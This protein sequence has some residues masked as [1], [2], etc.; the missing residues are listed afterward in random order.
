MT[1]NA[2]AGVPDLLPDDA[3][4]FFLIETA[5]R[6]VFSNYGYSYIQTPIF[7]LTDVFV[8]GIGDATDVV[9]K[10]MYH[11]F[12]QDAAKKLADNIALKSDQKLTLRPEG[13]A[14]IARAAV[15]HNLVQPKSAPVKLWYSGPMFRHERQQKGRYRQFHQIGAEFLGAFEPTADAEVI[16]MLMHFFASCG[17]PET[18]MR[19]TI[20]SMGDNN[21]RPAYR[22]SVRNFI[23]K[24]EDSLC[25]ECRR[26][27]DTNPLRAFDCKNPKCSEVMADAPRI[28][29]A[30]CM[31]CKQHYEQVKQILRDAGQSFSEDPRLVRGLDYYTRTVFEVQ[32]DAG[33]GAQNAIGGGGRYDKLLSEYG[34]KD[35]CGLGFAVG[36]ERI[37]LV[38]EEL[39]VVIPKPAHAELFVV[40]V[41]DAGLAGNDEASLELPSVVADTRRVAFQ[42][43][44]QLRKLGVSCDIDHQGRSLKSQF[45]LADKL[46]VKYCLVIG[47]DEL[48][49][50]S[51]ILR[52]MQSHEEEF[53]A[54]DTVV[55]EIKKRITGAI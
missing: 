24:H 28:S 16:I 47:S 29:D 13:T 18:A 45:K 4:T 17:I 37:K 35:V 10:E 36:M 11:V 40:V 27:A 53:L 21:C 32:V 5:A 48:D 42:I 52:N 9:G 14:G 1:L 20:N 7:E 31:P 44:Q 39:K 46:A 19:L 54:L 12:S 22:D 34:G 51:L 26:R 38:L 43:V 8:R 3:H 23:L 50:G 2:P 41:D 55:A 33:L 6:Q 49:R 30:L 15:Q 25:P